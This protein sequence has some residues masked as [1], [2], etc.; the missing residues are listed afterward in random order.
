MW[1]GNL[2]ISP[3]ATDGYQYV[4]IAGAVA[5]DDAFMVTGVDPT[6]FRF[7]VSTSGAESLNLQATGGEGYVDL[8]WNQDDF[9]TMLGF[10]IYRSETQD[11]GFTRI[12]QTLVGDQV[13][14][15]RDENMNQS[16]VLL[17]LHGGFGRC[18]IRAFEYC[19]S[20]TS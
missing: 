2:R 1:E 9:E 19:L 10:H 3:V 11:S 17:L 16:N 4:R 20:A 6:R 12:N 14:T 5:A 7:E 18:G 8:S 15:Y 13:R